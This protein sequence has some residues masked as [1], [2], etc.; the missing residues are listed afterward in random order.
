MREL[1]Q[2]GNGG[3]TRP[4]S[5]MGKPACLY[6][7]CPAATSSNHGPASSN[8]VHN[9][10]KHTEIIR[11]HCCSATSLAQAI[12][13]GEHDG[14]G[15]AQGRR[16]HTQ[17]HPHI[18]LSRRAAIARCAMSSAIQGSGQIR[19]WAGPWRERACAWH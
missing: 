3:R 16:R 15:S 12:E 11:L 13:P 1:G 9:S 5:R 2:H 18:L 10:S 14:E 6:A 19:R 8:A 17:S 4:A 7:L